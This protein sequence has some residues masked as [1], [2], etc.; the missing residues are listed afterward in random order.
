PRPRRSARSP[1]GSPPTRP[2]SAAP[3]IPA[4]GTTSAS[5]SGSRCALSSSSRSRSTTRA[6]T[7]SGTGPRSSAGATTKT[8]AN[9]GSSSPPRR[10]LEDRAHR[11]PAALADGVAHDVGRHAG[12]RDPHLDHRA[13]LELAVLEE[14]RERR[15]AALDLRSLGRERAALGLALAAHLDLAAGRDLGD[16][17]PGD[18]GVAA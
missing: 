4:A 1:R 6:T 16:R 8:R 12:R 15:A 5:S 2:A 17:E 14:L 7:A 11:R 13:G 9:A 3:A 18:A 10:R